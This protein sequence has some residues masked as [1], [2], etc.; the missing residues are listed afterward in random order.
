[1]DGTV[2]NTI[3]RTLV[4]RCGLKTGQDGLRIGV[5]KTPILLHVSF[6]WAVLQNYYMYHGGTNFGR[7]A[8]GPYITTSYDYD[9]PLDEFGNLNQPKW[10]HLKSSLEQKRDPIWSNN[11]TLRVNASGH[12]LHNY[13]PYFDTIQSGISRP[14]EL[15][16]HKGD[17]TI[18]KDLSS[19]KR[20]Y[21]VGL[22]GVDQKGYFKENCTV[23]W[24]SSELPIN[25]MMTWYK[26]TFKPPLGAEPVVVDLKEMGKGHAW[27]NG[28]SLGRYW[29][30]YITDADNCSLDPCDYRGSYSNGKCQHYHV[31]RSFLR[32]DENIL[33]LFEELGG[34]PTHVSF[35]TV[36][37]GKACVSANEGKTVVLAYQSGALIS[38]VEFA[39]YG[40]P[41]DACGAFYTG[42]CKSEK[43]VLAVVREACVGKE[44]CSLDVFDGVFGK[45][46]GESCGMAEINRKL[47][48]QVVC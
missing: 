20:T 14:V 15:V 24:R 11:M 40:D 12:V 8:G 22:S 28:Q 43:D 17:E 23:Q 25:S 31:P 35:K 42:A 19:H 30:G 27:V 21:K 3:R 2:T 9:A 13:G 18:I 29:P 1:M 45:V 4:L 26:T 37:T 32:D 33:V 16:S 10:G 36:T 46:S 41:K 44:V 48:V 5:E 34:N 39:S 6:N 7:T 47:A 38:D